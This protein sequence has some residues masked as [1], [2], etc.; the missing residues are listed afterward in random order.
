MSAALGGQAGAA[1][2]GAG[3]RSLGNGSNHNRVGQIAIRWVKSQVGG[4]GTTSRRVGGHTSPFLKARLVKHVF[5]NWWSTSC[6]NVEKCTTF[7]IYMFWDLSEK[8]RAQKL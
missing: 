1:G 3:E 4:P 6:E 8:M 7:T 2:R 5:L